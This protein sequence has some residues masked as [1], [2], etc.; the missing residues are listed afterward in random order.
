MDDIY[1]SR[2][3]QESFYTPGIKFFTVFKMF[4]IVKPSYIFMTDQFW[5]KPFCVISTVV[6][7]QR[8]DLEFAEKSF[9]LGEC[10]FCLYHLI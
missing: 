1:G 7:G 8:E 9:D 6:N 4:Y 3:K 2:P 10:C 5:S